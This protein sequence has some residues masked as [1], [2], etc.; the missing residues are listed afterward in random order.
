MLRSI[1]ITQILHF[2]QIF[3]RTECSAVHCAELCYQY[4]LEERINVE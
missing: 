4:L 3:E 2:G 1:V